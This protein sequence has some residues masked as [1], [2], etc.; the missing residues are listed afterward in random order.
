MGVGESG[1]MEECRKRLFVGCNVEGGNRDGEIA[2][3]MFTFT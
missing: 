3:Q 1:G 2:A